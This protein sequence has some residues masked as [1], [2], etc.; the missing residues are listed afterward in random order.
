MIATSVCIQA[1]EKMGAYVAE[2]LPEEEALVLKSHISC[3]NS[4][5]KRG[6]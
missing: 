5:K 4:Q 1:A 3:L 6:I 2:Q